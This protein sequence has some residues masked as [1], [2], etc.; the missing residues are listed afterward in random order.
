MDCD[1]TGLVKTCSNQLAVDR[2]SCEVKKEN[3]SHHE[4]PYMVKTFGYFLSLG[5]TGQSNEKENK[6]TKKKKNRSL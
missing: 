4:I 6:K 1:V 2:Q 3:G 5:S